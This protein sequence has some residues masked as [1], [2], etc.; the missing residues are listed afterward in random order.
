M[1]AILPGA[2]PREWRP[3]RDVTRQHTFAQEGHELRR[4]SNWVLR[5]P[6]V[7]TRDM[8]EHTL[9]L[10]AAALR[11]HRLPFWD[12]F[13]LLDGDR[14]GLATPAELRAGLAQSFCI[15]LSAE[16]V[17][18]LLCF[19]TGADGAPGLDYLSFVKHL[20]GGR[21]GL[22]WRALRPHLRSVL[23]NT[24]AGTPDDPMPCS[25]WHIFAGMDTR[26]AGLLGPD[27]LAAGLRALRVTGSPARIR[28][29]FREAGAE[30]ELSFPRFCAA[31]GV[32]TAAQVAAELERGE[33]W[34]ARQAHIWQCV[35]G[36]SGDREAESAESE[37]EADQ[38]QDVP[39]PQD[40]EPAAARS[41]EVNQ[42]PAKEPG[43]EAYCDAMSS[44]RTRREFTSACLQS[45]DAAK[46]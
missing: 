4:G 19:A 46:T 16:Q 26:R 22:L 39:R 7:A 25:L 3:G 6:A 5:P 38:P 23:A 27:E 14:D 20:H 9:G 42:G 36:V 43:W 45:L 11:H 12:A 8:V 10:L 24:S 37:H 1:A 30:S 34:A 41:L 40:R 35:D 33:R 21:D 15:A 44:V 32:R 13:Q 29:L 18:E 17:G 28:E 31:L 2:P